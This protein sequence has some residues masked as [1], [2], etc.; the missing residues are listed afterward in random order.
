MERLIN[1]HWP[2]NFTTDLTNLT[3]SLPCVEVVPV[4]DVLS[5]C[6]GN[7]STCL[8]FNVCLHHT[9]GGDVLHGC[10]D[11]RT[12]I[13]GTS[14]LTHNYC[15]RVGRGEGVII[16]RMMSWAW[17]CSLPAGSVG[18]GRHQPVLVCP[19]PARREQGWTGESRQARPQVRR[20]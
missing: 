5:V 20:L 6:D 15:R 13:S 14:M 10:R 2:A 8:L 18:R 12:G 17:L 9:V 19:P 11:D 3:S 1:T 16:R 4:N 7:Q